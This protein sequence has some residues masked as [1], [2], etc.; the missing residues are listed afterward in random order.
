MTQQPI[1]SEA[2]LARLAAAIREPRI[3][4]EKLILDA[5]FVGPHGSTIDASLFITFM[6]DEDTNEVVDVQPKLQIGAHMYP[7]NGHDHK[8]RAE[9]CAWLLTKVMQQSMVNAARAA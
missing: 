3:A 2:G 5:P 8:V 1:F 9:C 4:E 6:Y 7:Y